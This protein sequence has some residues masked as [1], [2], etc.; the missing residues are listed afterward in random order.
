MQYDFFMSL[1]KLPWSDFFSLGDCIAGALWD[2][3]DGLEKQIKGVWYKTL[4]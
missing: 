4:I 3:N 1:S 2:V